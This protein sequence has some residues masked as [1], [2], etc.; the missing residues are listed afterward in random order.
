M[1]TVRRMLLQM[2][3]L[4]TENIVITTF[5]LRSGEPEIREKKHPII[6]FTVGSYG[7]EVTHYLT[8]EDEIAQAYITHL[9]KTVANENTAK[10]H[11]CDKYLQVKSAKLWKRLKYLF[12]PMYFK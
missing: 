4:N 6:G 12:N 11:W 8:F 5:K 9:N 7:K 3:V 10:I 1:K 2:A